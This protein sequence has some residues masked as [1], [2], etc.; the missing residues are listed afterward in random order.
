MISDCR[1]A[2]LKLQLNWNALWILEMDMLMTLKESMLNQSRTK[3]AALCSAAETLLAVLPQRCKIGRCCSCS[4]SLPKAAPSSYL[5]AI[6]QW[7]CSGTWNKNI[8]L[9]SA[10]KITKM[11]IYSIGLAAWAVVLG[12]KNFKTHIL[13]NTKIIT[14]LLVASDLQNY[15]LTYDSSDSYHL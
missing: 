9:K 12:G 1:K 2:L 5:A 7:F 14:S 11:Y 4:F 13:Y 6:W 3:R 15:I 8:V 10:A